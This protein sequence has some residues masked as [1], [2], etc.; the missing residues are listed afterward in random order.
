M[1]V[2][3]PQ[4]ADTQLP[5]LISKALSGNEIAITALAKHYRDKGEHGKAVLFTALDISSIGCLE[6]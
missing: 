5:I 4:A 1:T 3:Q 2:A 6:A